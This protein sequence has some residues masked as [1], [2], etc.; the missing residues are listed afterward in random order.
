VALMFAPTQP[1]ATVPNDLRP[2]LIAA[3]MMLGAS[4]PAERARARIGMTWDE[5]IAPGAA[6][7][8]SRKAAARDAA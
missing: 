4:H 1:L 7:S 6:E 2:Q 5:L 3:L 8:V